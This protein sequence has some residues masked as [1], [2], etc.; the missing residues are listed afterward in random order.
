MCSSKLRTWQALRS[1]RLYSP[2][3]GIAEI[4][5]SLPTQVGFVPFGA[6]NLASA[7][8]QATSFAGIQV[9]FV[10]FRAANLPSAAEQAALFAEFLI[11][12]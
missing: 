4:D 8:E 5:V 2:E 10:L 3:S 12:R 7:A 11:D 1:K 9:G 6:A